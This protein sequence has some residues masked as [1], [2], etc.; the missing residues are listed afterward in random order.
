MQFY[1]RR[2]PIFFCLCAGI[3]MTLMMYAADNLAVHAN[4]SPTLRFF[5]RS[6]AGLPAIWIFAWWVNRIKFMESQNP[7]SP[8]R[9]DPR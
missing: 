1:G 5:V 4:S 2:I 7:A 3:A 8:E 9:S 6:V